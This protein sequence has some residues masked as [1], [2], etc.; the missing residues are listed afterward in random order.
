MIIQTSIILTGILLIF[1]A[2]C[3][4]ARLLMGPTLLD[5]VMSL[6]YLTFVGIGGISLLSIYFNDPI[7]LDIATVFALVGFLATI[8]F[9]RY[10]DVKLKRGKGVEQLDD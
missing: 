9:A 5:R 4:F 1:G 3:G 10:A 6:D 7:Y 8:A 2:F